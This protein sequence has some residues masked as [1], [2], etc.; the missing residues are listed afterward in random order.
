MMPPR[1]ASP[2]PV[3]PPETPPAGPIPLRWSDL[4]RIPSNARHAFG[5]LRS[6]DPRLA[7][8]L[9]ALALLEAVLP[10][11]MAW[12]GKRIIDT[13]VA[14]RETGLPTGH[15][16][17]WVG[18]EGALMLLRTAVSQANSLAQTLLAG[19]LSVEVNGRILEKAINV[20]YR[21][22]EDPAFNDRLA[23][24]R[25]EA[26]TRPLDVVRQALA[27]GRNILTLL[28]FGAVLGAFSPLAALALLASSVPS[29]LAEAKYGSM[30]FVAKRRRTLAMRSAGYFESLL[31]SEP[32]VKEMKLFSL[33]RWALD[34]YLEFYR[35]FRDEDAD[36]ARRRT[37]DGFAL[38]ALSL[39][40]LY[41]CYAW[42]VRRAVLGD[43]TVG[44]MTFYLVAFREGQAAFQAGLVAIAKLY[45]DNLFM[46]NLTEYLAVPE[47]EPHEPIPS[48]P[49]PD[50]P[51]RVE[52][53]RV[54]FRYP[55]AS[56][57]TL[58]DVTLVIEPGETLALVGPNGAGKTTL[59]KLLCG[60]YRPTAG[61][62]RIDGRDVGTMSPAEL[63]A[64]VGVIF[65]DFVRFH[66][67]LAENIGVGWL[68]DRDDRVA[69]ERAGDAG[70]LGDVVAGLT[71]GYDERLGR[72]FG[73]TDLSVGQWQRLALARAFMR[74]SRL[75]VLDEPTSALDAEHEAETFA[76][77]RD[78]ASDRTALLITHRFSTVRLADRI[79]VFEDGRLTELGTHAELLASGRRYARMFRLQAAGYA[80]A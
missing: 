3:L 27:L 50:R 80:E 18:V 58:V 21:H 28:G 60:L 10:V 16:L 37:R 20:S 4:A 23:Q 68:P 67:T 40:V 78:L 51:P 64:R 15:A 30:S 62:I 33:S 13:V 54:S 46:S 45:E 36:L 69:I 31:S 34:R 47:D 14:G 1:H 2:P 43:F 53:D 72:W 17:A 8:A 38:G 56:R 59:V 49:L 41:G 74:R 12:V 24:A 65:Q 22:F 61:T 79:A 48:E 75:L 19:A 77:F 57:D 26:S 32:T 5:F 42:V 6:A 9:V 76:R 71:G 35:S 25:R 39:V 29:F 11:A 63:R 55:G 70:G 66:L 73:G 44:T 52:L 7:V